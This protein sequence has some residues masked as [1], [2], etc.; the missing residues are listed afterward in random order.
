MSL[1][2]V[3]ECFV[4]RQGAANLPLAASLQGA[5]GIAYERHVMLVKTHRGGR[6]ERHHDLVGST[7]RPGGAKKS[8]A[9]GKAFQAICFA[10][11]FA[12]PTSETMQLHIREYL[13]PHKE[14]IGLPTFL[15][16]SL[17]DP[18]LAS[19]RQMADELFENC[20]LALANERR[21]FANHALP[22][23]ARRYEPV[24][25]FLVAQHM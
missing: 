18:M 23:E 15:F 22:D 6:A 24:A 12:G 21:P 8:R 1:Q 11:S 13:G 10:L 17:H 3:V 2:S 7:C 20:E 5:K 4:D 9:P 14:R 19:A 16:G 25:K